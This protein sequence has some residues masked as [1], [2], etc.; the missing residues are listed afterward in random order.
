MALT[1]FNSTTSPAVEVQQ[2]KSPLDRV[3]EE[4]R[5]LI[6]EFVL[7]SGSLK[8]LAKHYGVSYPTI[9]TRLDGV[10]ERL[11]AAVENRPADPLAEALAELVQR[12]ELTASGARRVLAAAEAKDNIE[13]GGS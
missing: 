13:K 12:G 11:R 4:D 8:D 3:P 10:I 5:A 2:A 7:R 6:I 9:R 1:S